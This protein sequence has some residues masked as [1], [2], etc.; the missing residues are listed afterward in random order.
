M[1]LKKLSKIK[2]SISNEKNNKKLLEFEDLKTYIDDVTEVRDILNKEKL[3]KKY[4][5]YKS[6]S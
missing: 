2:N 5:K 4:G 3:E 6:K 1:E